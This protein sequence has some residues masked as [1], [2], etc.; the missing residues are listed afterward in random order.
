MKDVKNVFR[1]LEK[2]LKQ[3]HWFDDEWDI[4]NRGSYLQLYK[5]NWHNHNQG[6]VHFETFIEGPQIKHKAF[7]ICVHAEEDCPYQAKFIEE[8]LR[9]EGERI[10]AW[11]GYEAAGNGYNICQRTLP[12]NYKNLEN[13]IFEEFN[14]LR[15]LEP[16]IDQVLSRL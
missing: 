12:L 14:Q 11:K 9:L 2:K 4:Y 10:R 15:Q 8:L 3:S 7:P 1:T 6:G 13:R 5:S 16:A